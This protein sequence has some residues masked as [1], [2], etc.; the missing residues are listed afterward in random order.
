MLEKLQ[1]L[2]EEQKQELYHLSTIE[3]VYVFAKSNNIDLTPEEAANILASLPEDTLD[4]VSGGKY[5]TFR[6]CRNCG[7]IGPEALRC[8]CGERF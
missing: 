8:E 2:T 5:G 4:G 3:E 7:R 1:A 6:P